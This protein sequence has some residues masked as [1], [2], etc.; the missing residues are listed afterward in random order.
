MDKSNLHSKFVQSRVNEFPF[1][2]KRDAHKISKTIPTNNFFFKK[3]RKRELRPKIQNCHHIAAKV[4]F[5]SASSAF[6]K[7]P[8]PFINYNVSLNSTCHGEYFIWF[9]TIIIFLTGGK[10]KNLSKKMLTV[11]ACEPSTN[12]MRCVLVF[13]CVKMVSSI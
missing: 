2:S 9:G 13:L 10:N 7:N 12:S 3:K 6:K 5:I 8:K 1:V 4:N 11:D